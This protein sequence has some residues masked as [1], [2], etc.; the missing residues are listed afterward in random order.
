MVYYHRVL[1]NMH[2]LIAKFKIHDWPSPNGLIMTVT[3]HSKY[4]ESGSCGKRNRFTAYYI[5]IHANYTSIRPADPVKS[6]YLR[7]GL[8]IQFT[9]SVLPS[10]SELILQCQKPNNLI[11]LY[12]CSIILYSYIQPGARKVSRQLHVDDSGLGI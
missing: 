8:D 6:I 5:I 3:V 11:I 12:L 9:I 10:S 1:V 4:I 2:E 7:I